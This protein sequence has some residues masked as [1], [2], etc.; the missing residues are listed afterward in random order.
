MSVFLCRRSQCD[1][2]YWTKTETFTSVI[3]ETSVTTLIAEGL[4]GF[5]DQLLMALFFSD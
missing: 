2:V 4:D 3:L 1:K 5:I